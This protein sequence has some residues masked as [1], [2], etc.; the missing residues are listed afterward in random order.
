MLANNWNGEANIETLPQYIFVFVNEV[1]DIIISIFR[2]PCI[3]N[4]GLIGYVPIYPLEKSPHLSPQNIF[5]ARLK[6]KKN[7]IKDRQKTSPIYTTLYRRREREHRKKSAVKH[8]V[9]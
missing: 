2:S 7:G 5:P 1:F 3:L 9:F 4:L 8:V 6:Q